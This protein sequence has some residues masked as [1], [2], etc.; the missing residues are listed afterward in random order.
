M[1]CGLTF[2]ADPAAHVQFTAQDEA[3][4]V[5]DSLVLVSSTRETA[6]RKSHQTFNTFIQDVVVGV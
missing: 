6:R 5:H 1:R 3:P 2:L 4:P